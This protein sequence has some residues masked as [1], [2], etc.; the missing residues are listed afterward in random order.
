LQSRQALLLRWR[1]T[2]LVRLNL[3]LAVVVL[4]LTALAR[5]S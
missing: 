3:L 5:V 4:A 1:H 2:F